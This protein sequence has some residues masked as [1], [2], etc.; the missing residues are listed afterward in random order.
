MRLNYF[1]ENYPTGAYHASVLSAIISQCETVSQ[2]SESK[3][4]ILR[5]EVLENEMAYKD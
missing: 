3:R 1:F 4:W 2:F 5:R